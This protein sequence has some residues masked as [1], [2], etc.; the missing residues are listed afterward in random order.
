LDVEDLGRVYEALL[1]LEPG[2][3]T[4]PMCRLRRAKLEVVVPLDQGAPYRDS[5]AAPGDEVDDLEEPEEAGHGDD[6]GDGGDDAPR[7]RRRAGGG[8]KT[9]VEFV[10]DIPAGRFFLRVG[11]GRKATGSYYTPHPFVRFLVQETLGPQLTERSPKEDPQPGRI[12]ELKVLDPAMGSGHFLVEACRYLGDALYEACRLCDELAVA[13]EE[14]A[15]KAKGPERDRLL[16]EAATFRQR[17]VDLPDPDDELV[18]YLPSRAPEG[19]ASGLS[20]RKA[21]A[22]CRRL[23]AVHCLYGVDKNPLAVE[24]AKLSLSLWLE[25]YAEGLPLTFMDHRLVCGDSLT[26]PFFEHML[27]YP[28]TG[29]EIDDLCGQGLRERLRETVAA[30]MAHVRDLEASVGTDVADLEH[31][32]G[33]KERLDAALVPLK[34][35]A[36]AWSGGV[37]L[38]EKCDD[39][40]YLELARAVADGAEIDSVLEARPRLREMVREGEGGVAFQLVFPEVFGVGTVQEVFGAG[41]GRNGFDAVVGNPP[42]DAIQFKSKEFLAAFDLR[43]LDAPTKRERTEVESRLLAEETVA[44][45]FNS[46]QES[47]ERAKRSN[48]RLF[49]YQKVTI[50]GDLAGRQLDAFRVF[51][52]RNTQLVGAEGYTGVVVPSA[53]HANAGAT[54]VRRLYLEKMA[55]QCCFSF[56]NRKKLFDIDSRFKF[57][58]VVARIDSAATDEFECGFYWHDLERLFNPTERLRYGIEFVRRTGGEFLTLLEGRSATQ[59]NILNTMYARSELLGSWMST[60]GIAPNTSELPM[61][62]E[63]V[64]LPAPDHDVRQPEAARALLERGRLPLHEGKTIHQFDDLWES[65]PRYVVAIGGLTDRPRWLQLARHYRFG[66]RAISASTNERT[67]IACLMAPPTVSTRKVAS[68]VA[69]GDHPNAT[70]LL[71]CAVFNTHSL[72]FVFVRWSRPTWDCSS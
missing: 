52:E 34:T 67:G 25:S 3:T 5:G 22:L 30:A 49:E 16:A 38:G 11:L 65:G 55:L 54:G 51:M 6:E 8:S 28:G 33:A 1:E 9:K 26:G 24:L 53:F 56:E 44:R 36:A 50:E 61:L 43:I 39:S 42:W 48:D 23:V 10:E 4:E 31:K 59:V 72:D 20:Q 64:F 60:R 17:V 21:E 47:F 7:S 70:S 13:A 68:D 45:L 35:L 14:R 63:D 57:A 29:G 32:R 2:I 12:L 27:T 18:A 15:A 37:M 71:L 58:A 40:G 46:H 41:A 69:A 62:G 66:Y 19:E